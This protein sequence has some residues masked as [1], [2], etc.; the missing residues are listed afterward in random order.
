MSSSTIA[1][2][3]DFGLHDWYVGVMKGVILS[4]APNARIIDIT[5]DVPRH[6][7]AAASFALLASYPHFP[8][9]SILVTVVDPGV[10]TARRIICVQ[11]A[12]RYFLA[13]DNGV[14]T[15]VL[16]REGSEKMVSVENG[17]YFLPQVSST[18]HGRDI[19]APVA[20]H[21][22][23]G[24][25]I[26]QLGPEVTVY[27]RLSIPRPQVASQTA[28]TTVQWVDSFGNL[29]TDCPRQLVG[30]LGSRWGA[31]VIDLGPRGV[32]PIAETYEMVEPDAPMGVIGSSD[33]LE[34]SIR[35]G[36]ASEVLGL[37]IGHKVVLKPG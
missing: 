25:A 35:E 21:L 34:I 16:A 18:F 4:V 30:E 2:L 23:S 13:P 27:K 5:H 15:G 24:V 29:V 26:D 32:A 20:G 6:N 12:G 1:L 8:V 37:G 17:A 22:S 7:L 11:S 19:F 9:G 31:V 3:T 33:Y 14:L 36:S 28:Q 10:G